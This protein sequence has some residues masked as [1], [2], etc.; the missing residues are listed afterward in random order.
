MK[1]CRVGPFL[2]APLLA[3]CAVTPTPGA[4]GSPSPNAPAVLAAYKEFVTCLRQHGV[5]NVPDPVVDARGNVGL[6]PSVQISQEA[7]TA[8]API[9]ARLPA[10]KGREPKYTPPA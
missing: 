5:P 2:V 1:I 10:G 8:C 4:A 7:K 6:G 9:V 3:A